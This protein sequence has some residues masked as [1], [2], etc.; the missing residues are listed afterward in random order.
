M[1][2]KVL[3]AIGVVVFIVGL[4]LPL[5]ILP[6]TQQTIIEKTPTQ[7]PISS[8]SP[9]QLITIIP[10]TS[11]V[12]SYRDLLER[13][14]SQARLV[15]YTTQLL[16]QLRYA[17]ALP[18]VQPLVI[19]VTSIPIITSAAVTETSLLRGEPSTGLK[20]TEYSLTNVQVSGVDEQDIVKT[21]GR[22]IAI[23][24]SS[25]VVVLDAFEKRAVS[26]INTTSVKGLYLVN[27]TLVV[28]RVEPPITILSTITIEGL[29]YPVT[30]PA[31][32]EILVYDLSE[33]SSPR[34]QWQLN[35]TSV[36]AGSRLVDK[37]LY[38]VGYMDSFKYDSEK[39]VLVPVIPLVNG[40]PISRGNIVESGNYTSYIVVVVFD[41][42]SGE[43]IANAFTGGVVRWIYMVPDRLYVAWSDP[44][45]QYK[46]FLEFLDHLALKGLVS[47][48]KVE[49]FKSMLKQ[50]LIIEVLEEIR[51][52]L[53]DLQQ[54]LREP[55]EVTD[56]TA[57]LVLDVKGLNINERGVFKVPGSVLDQFAMEEF[58]SNHGRFMVIATTVNKYTVELHKTSLCPPTPPTSTI[59]IIII[60]ERKGSTKSTRT[61]EITTTPSQ[62]SCEPF[63]FWNFNVRESV[64][65]VYIV[66]EELKI[67]SKLEDLAPG[68][69]V[70]AA[71]LLKNIF[72]LVTF[73]TIDPLFAIDLS[74]PYNPRVLGYLKIPGFSE[75]LH[76]VSENSLLGVGREDW[77]TLKIS[78]FNI[79]DPTKI[80]EVAKLIIGEYAWSEV[81]TDHHAFTIDS[82]HNIVIMPVNIMGVWEG[83]AIIE[84]SVEDSIVRLKSLVD[85]ERPM[86]AL[87]INNNLYFVGYYRTLV[88]NLP[89]LGFL[90]EIKY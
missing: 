54:D 19:P 44:L 61:I 12:E 74:D 6:L 88:Y 48:S 31:L 36:F 38:V 66:N 37:Y 50:G 75:Y 89:E 4:L 69:R 46:V 43:Y 81:F 18:T 9:S 90:G 17:Y 57:F 32:I 16:T 80:V 29:K 23:A 34:L 86:R 64:N 45:S 14:I 41:I 87:Y 83:F 62:V 71:R 11:Q 77:R 79:S 60:E 25:D 85:L 28:I 39:N 3:L 72:Y 27:N 1:E 35:F 78:L 76:P 20:S 52:V 47:S 30:Y 51:K 59:R 15:I 67:V 2:V 82:R 84:Y 21:N 13:I 10:Q 55:I 63:L 22:V 24:R 5:T 26:Y 65:S 53:K 68:E 40:K 8:P 49:E 73:R 7:T 58:Y 70:Y 42:T 56:E 33:P